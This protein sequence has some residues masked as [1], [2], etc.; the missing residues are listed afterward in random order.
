MKIW[1]PSRTP[2]EVALSRRTFGR[3]EAIVLGLFN[4]QVLLKD[5]VLRHL[6]DDALREP[7]RS[8]ALALASRWHEDPESLSD[9]S[10]LIVRSSG[11]RTAD[12]LLALRR[13]EVAHKAVPEDAGCLA[14]FGMA[15]YRVGRDHEAL[16]KLEKA[17]QTYEAT[18]RS[19][20]PTI[21]A[22]LAM[23]HQRLGHHVEAKSELA[24]FQSLLK[25][26][27]WSRSTQLQE[28]LHEAEAALSSR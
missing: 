1:D 24:R 12:Y 10:R 7:I 13:A 11:N 8:A 9:A 4:G 2:S 3:T 25:S 21:V 23:A 19:I 17:R 27:R 5:E 16:E 15:L 28:L 26:Q 18:T 22:F 14:T 6:R 20:S